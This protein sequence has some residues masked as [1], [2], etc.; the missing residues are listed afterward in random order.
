MD[1]IRTGNMP[2]EKLREVL[3]VNDA[4]LVYKNLKP[5]YEWDALICGS[6]QLHLKEEFGSEH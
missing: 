6:T 2:S 3:R 4:L 1:R 5:N